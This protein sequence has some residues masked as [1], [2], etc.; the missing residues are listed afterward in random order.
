M[1]VIRKSAED[2]ALRET[3]QII[4]NSDDSGVTMVW[5]CLLGCDAAGVGVSE[6]EAKRISEQFWT[7]LE[8]E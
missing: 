6:V 8:E 4:G 7:G 2:F 3:G 1:I 5:Q